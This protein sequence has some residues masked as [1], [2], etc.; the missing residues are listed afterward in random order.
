MLPGA[1]LDSAAW[2]TE[3]GFAAAATALATWVTEE[4][5]LGSMVEE[6]ALILDETTV[7][8]DTCD[9]VAEGLVGAVVLSEACF[10]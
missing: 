10:C 5:V 2:G 4:I 8:V 9:G 3:G 6:G 1:A 7:L